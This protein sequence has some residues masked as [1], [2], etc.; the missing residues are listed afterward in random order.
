M[1][2]QTLFVPVEEPAGKDSIL[3]LYSVKAQKS[4]DKGWWYNKVDIPDELEKVVSVYFD[5]APYTAEIMLLNKEEKQTDVYIA[6]STQSV[7]LGFFISL[8]QCVHHRTFKSKWDSITITGNITVHEG[9]VEPVGVEHITEKFKGVQSHA[10]EHPDE[11]HLFLYVN[12]EKPIEPGLY[13]NN[14]EV[15]AFTPKDSIGAIIAEL[16]E[17]TEKQNRRINKAGFQQRWEYVSTPVFEDMKRDA[18]AKDWNGFLIHGEGESGKS[19]LAFE[20]AKYLVAAERIYAPLWIKVNNEDLRYSF[21]NIGKP[22]T[23]AKPRMS[24]KDARENFI[25]SSS[26]GIRPKRNP[27]EDPVTAYIAELLA[28]SLNLTEWKPEDG[29]AAL[30]NSIKRAGN[31]P[32]LLIID[33]LEV[34]EIDKVMES[35]QTI[36]GECRP[37]PPVIFT[38]RRKGD[39]GN[40]KRVRPSEFKK[41]ELE[42]FI[43]NI[44]QKEYA[45]ELASWKGEKRYNDFLVQVSAHFASFPGIIEVIVSQLLD[46]G[47]AVVLRS[48]GD[49]RLLGESADRKAEAIYKMAF[50]ELD[51]FTQAVLFAFIDIIQPLIDSEKDNAPQK[52]SR[53]VSFDSISLQQEISTRISKAGLRFNGCDYSTA[54]LEEKTQQALDKLVRCHLLNR[55]FSVSAY[56]IKTLPLKIFL[57]SESTANDIIFES[58]KTLRDTLIDAE[59]LIKACICYNQSVSRLVALLKKNNS[60]QCKGDIFLFNAACH[61]VI[62]GHIDALIEHGYKNTNEAND[63]DGQTLLHFAAAINTNKE[64]VERLFHYGADASKKNADGLTPLHYAA[65]SNRSPDIIALLIKKGAAIDTPDNDGQIPLHYAAENDNNDIFKY[66]AELNMTLLYCKDAGGITPLFEFLKQC[67][68]PA[69]IRWLLKH[70]IDLSRSVHNIGN[71]LLHYAAINSGLAITNED[72]INILV[73]KGVNIN[74]ANSYGFTPL[75]HAA[76]YNENPDRVKLLLDKGAIAGIN[77]KSSD[78]ITPLHAAVVHNGNADIIKLLLKNGADILAKDNNDATVFHGIAIN[79]RLCLM[80]EDIITI[81]REKGLN[82]NAV[83]SSGNTP[84][85]YAAM[86]NKSPDSITF[87]FEKGAIDDINAKNVFGS[88]PLHHAAAHNGNADIMKLLL[89]NGA[90]ILARENDGSTILHNAAANPH[91]S[92]VIEDITTFLVEKGLSINAVDSNGNT[93]LHYAALHNK[94]SDLEKTAIPKRL[95]ELLRFTTRQHSTKPLKFP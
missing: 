91:L 82:I 65:W 94:N 8:I 85:H 41:E 36:I 90:D 52:N 30:V 10:G 60:E 23:S 21:F 33:H 37:R 86:H 58:G 68:D 70:N 53:N 27:L 31:R 2:N 7:L 22:S 12:K 43:E 46:R 11:N 40:F 28:E 48:L 39:I 42:K 6:G 17:L 4:S 72:M 34:D 67:S 3:S 87:L 71:T 79:P 92:A 57:F 13:D 56:Y 20:L 83:D 74:A 66:L 62:P 64:V 15:K 63:T 78:G 14:L 59:Y 18:L 76:A 47:L 69:I 16:F 54:E 25:H 93:P 55:D 77:A 61:S 51:D 32:Y 80:N 44:A 84:L 9:I 29:L 1:S 73:G 89:K 88:T 50:S 26:I 35:V 19:A 38:S 81:F 75:Y 24:N 49:L 95:R 5:K 45:Q